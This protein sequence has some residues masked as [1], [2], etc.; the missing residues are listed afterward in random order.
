MYCSTS[1]KIIEISMSLLQKG[2]VLSFRALIRQGEKSVI[3]YILKI[4]SLRSK[5]K[6]ELFRYAHNCTSLRYVRK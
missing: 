5:D 3:P 4:S 2:R 1:D 6:K